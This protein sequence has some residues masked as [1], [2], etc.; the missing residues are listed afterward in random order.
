MCYKDRDNILSPELL[1]S[2][3]SK[4]DRY[5]AMYKQHVLS[6][7]GWGTWKRPAHSPPAYPPHWRQCGEG[8][9]KTRSTLKKAHVLEVEGYSLKS[10]REDVAGRCVTLHLDYKILNS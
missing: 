5:R 9:D 1:G 3:H 4:G 2:S 8:G 7:A 6:H 10:S